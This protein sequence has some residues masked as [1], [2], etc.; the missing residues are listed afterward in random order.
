M[1]WYWPRWGIVS[2]EISRERECWYGPRLKQL[3]YL[4]HFVWLH[5]ILLSWNFCLNQKELG[6]WVIMAQILT[7]YLNL[8]IRNVNSIT[9]H[10]WTRREVEMNAG[11]FNL[12]IGW[13]FLLKGLSKSPLSSIP[14]FVDVW[15]AY[16][17]KK[18][19]KLSF[20]NELN[21]SSQENLLP[22]ELGTH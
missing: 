15:V 18:L 12:K 7:G 4:S 19:C 1:L 3:H 13:D 14:A 11:H 20:Q 16:M 17:N 2:E 8:T 9:P 22:G 10:V 5:Y 6:H 21:K